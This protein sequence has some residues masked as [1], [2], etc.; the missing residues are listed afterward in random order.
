[1]VVH[2]YTFRSDV[3]KLP[4]CYFGNAAEEYIRFFKLGVDGVFTDFPA[5]AR[6]ARELHEKLGDQFIFHALENYESF[7]PEL[8]RDARL[9]ESKKGSVDKPLSFR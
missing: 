5:H 2:P 1:M 9:R 6:Y 4:E 3:L 8:K 7:H